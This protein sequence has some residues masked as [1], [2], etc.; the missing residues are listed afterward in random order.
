[1]SRWKSSFAISIVIN[2]VIF[3]GGAVYINYYAKPDAE[4]KP[5]PIEMEIVSDSGGGTSAPQ[6]VVP[7]PEKV[8][9]PP[10]P[11]QE[12]VKQIVDRSIPLNDVLNKEDVQKTQSTS[13]EINPNTKQDSNT[14]TSQVN[15]SRQNPGPGPTPTPPQP[16]HHEDRS[17]SPVPL[18]TPYPDLPVIPA[19]QGTTNRAVAGFVIDTDG[20]TRDI[21]IEVS[22]GYGPADDAIIS[23]ISS[24][25]FKPGTDYDGNPIPVHTTR[26]FKLEIK[27]K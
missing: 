2:I 20:S 25:S 6:I 5:E 14:N 27:D 1:M 18:S 17:H 24:W 11:T 8:E 21:V 15:K 12:E 7:K 16:E 19:D 3:L 23:A 9:I 13:S 22:S 4:H 26:G 10:T